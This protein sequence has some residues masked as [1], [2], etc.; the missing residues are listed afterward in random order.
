[1]I[2]EA[3]G[4]TDFEE[5]VDEQTFTPWADKGWLAHNG[6]SPEIAVCDFVSSLVRMMQPKVVIETGVGQGYVTRVIASALEGRGGHLFAF[7]SDDWWREMMVGQYF[8]VERKQVATLSQLVTPP[9]E[10]IVAADLAV[11]DS[12]FDFRFAE[13]EWWNE[14]AKP[15]AVALIHDTADRDGTVHQSVRGL[16][17]E[18]GMTG[19]FLQNPRGAFMAVQ[20]KEK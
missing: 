6:Q 8:W 13:I 3:N 11:I 19:V 16:I 10:L 20:P 9:V 12:D 4:W 14:Y 5:A 7:E 15:G 2:P 18:L 17:T 1:M